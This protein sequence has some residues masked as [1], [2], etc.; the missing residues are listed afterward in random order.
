MHCMCTVK[1]GYGTARNRKPKLSIQSLTEGLWPPIYGHCIHLDTA[2]VTIP[3]LDGDGV[4]Q[5]WLDVIQQVIYI[6]YLIVTTIGLG[7]AHDP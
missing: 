7:Y 5:P 3:R 2:T 6:I 1:Y 4:Y